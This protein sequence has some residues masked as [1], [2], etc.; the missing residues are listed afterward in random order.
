MKIEKAHPEA[1]KWAREFHNLYE[2]KA[3][4]FGYE[5]KQETREFNPESPNGRLMAYVCLNIVQQAREED[6]KK[7]VEVL[8]EHLYD[9]MPH[10]VVG[11]KPR[12]VV[13]GNSLKQDEARVSAFSLLFKII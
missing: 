5:T 13:N 3:P 6:R 2:H 1:Y 4:L 9:Q 10:N 11:T 12:W 7:A 8:A